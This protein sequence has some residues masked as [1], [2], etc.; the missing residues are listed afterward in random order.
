MMF[1]LKALT[2]KMIKS[3]LTYIRAFFNGDG[4]N[5]APNRIIAGWISHEPG[6][7]FLKSMIGLQ[8]RNPA[9]LTDEEAR[10]HLRL[11]HA[12]EESWRGLSL[13]PQFTRVREKETYDARFQRARGKA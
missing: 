10:E 6:L 12:A 9:D 5:N 7:P 3:G 4:I 1:L 8:T 2:E 13:P 11:Y